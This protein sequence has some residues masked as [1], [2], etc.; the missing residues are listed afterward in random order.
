MGKVIPTAKNV[1][2]D[3]DNVATSM[4]VL[5]KNG[6]AT[7][8]ATTYYNAMLN[9]L[10]KSGS[11]ADQ[12]LR[13]LSGKGFA[14][15]V[16]EGV[17]VTEILGMLNEEAQKNGKYLSD[18]F[19]S[20]EA[21]KAALTIMKEDGKEYNEILKQM[22]GSAGAAQS[23]FEKMDATPAAKMQKELNKLKNTGIELGSKLLPTVNSLMDGLGKLVDQFNELTPA[24]Q[25]SL[26]KATAFAAALGPVA[27]VAGSTTKGI[28]SLTDGAGALLKKL[29]EKAAIST[30]AKGIE[31]VGASAISATGGVSGFAG[32]LSK[33]ASPAGIAVLA[34]TAVVG[35]GAAF[36]KAKKDAAEADIEAHFGKIKLSAEE[37]EK[38]A[39]RL[40]SNDWIMKIDAVIDAK[41][42]LNEFENQLKNTL[43][44]I[45]KTEWKV[46]IGLEPTED[47]KTS[48]RDSLSNY[49]KQATE[50]LEQ[51]H[52]TT[53]LAIDAVLK[54]GTAAHTNYKAMADE[55]YNGLSS[56]LSQLG[57]ELSELVNEAFE[58]NILSADEL[59]VID[60]K[61][62]E[63]QEKLDELNRAHFLVELE[64]VQIKASKEGISKESFEELQ[65]EVTK[66]IKE[67]KEA[68][69]KSKIEALVPLELQFEKGEISQEEYDKAKAQIE[70]NTQKELGEVVLDVVDISIGTL[71]SNYSEE[72]N[73]KMPEFQA[74]N[75][76]WIN[77]LLTLTDQ[78]MQN[79]FSIMEHGLL[80]KS[81]GLSEGAAAA[82]KDILEGLKPQK[83][84]LEAIAQSCLEAGELVPQNVRDGLAKIGEK[85]AAIGEVDG[86]YNQIA[87]QVANSPEYFE[88]IKQA[89]KNGVSIPEELITAIGIYSGQIYDENTGMWNEAKQAAAD[90]KP[91]LTYSFQGT[92][93]SAV[94]GAKTAFENGSLGISN[95][96]DFMLQSAKNKAY[97]KGPELNDTFGQ[98]G[99]GGATSFAGGISS[100]S[101]VAAG[102]MTGMMGNV[103]GLFKGFGLP[104]IG[105]QEGT[106][107][108]NQTSAA[109]SSNK[110]QVN[111]STTAMAGEVGASLYAANLTS[112]GKQYGEKPILG[113]SNAMLANMMKVSSAA[114]QIQR[115]LE[116]K[117]SSIDS[118]TW[119]THL[120][121]GFASGMWS[122]MG[123]VTSAARSIASAASRYLHFSR[124]DEGPLRNYEQWPA[125]FIDRYTEL[126]R[127]QRPKMQSAA[128][129]VADSVRS[130]LSLEGNDF[131]LSAFSQPDW[132]GTLDIKS[133]KD[134]IDYDRLAQSIGK[135]ID[136]DKIAQDFAKAIDDMDI[137][138]TGDFRGDFIVDGK[139]TGQALAPFI[140]EAMARLA[141]TRKRG[142]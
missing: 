61:Q 58:D 101:P 122:R 126:L 47:E 95:A 118:Y 90:A 63:I 117:L 109:I 119:G 65:A 6:I 62:Q 28:A 56:E 64:N 67:R 16:A 88:A 132:Q 51:Q 141:I 72:L 75:D 111:D 102:A 59:A 3:I 107:F 131:D 32:I 10:G 106:D 123:N 46:S 25:K 125:H 44:E 60:E 40:T 98:V 105:A 77:W 9:E 140:D 57:I 136:G 138:V 8:E 127:Q 23:A 93:E 48:Y 69:E 30:A 50:Y 22:Q 18:M 104:G 84:E 12:T 112:V 55:F 26:L 139:S 5:T 115:S 100:G 7:A 54:P 34:T 79:Q 35:I 17:P 33:L 14:Q 53:S 43:D 68:I 130:S 21:S 19:G 2:V 121:S 91:E 78:D 39:K 134:Y 52:F 83:E 124:P 20:A 86:L 31:G 70:L 42:K 82:T 85:E 113:F 133:D 27:K 129:Y 74:A 29:G 110:W 73:K 71:D 142:G 99:N 87:Q 89:Q 38:T 94:T 66:L 137:R 13:N 92:A 135:A 103:I 96:T 11:A 24:Q 114:L 108:V 41:E 49:V 1:N 81:A 36:I 97:E 80:R 37:V 128:A 76:H 116:N 15:L 4:A 45:K 120:V